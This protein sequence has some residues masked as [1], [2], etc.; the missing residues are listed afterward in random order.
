MLSDKEF[1]HNAQAVEH[2]GV[3]FMHAVNNRTLKFAAG[4]LA[5]DPFVG[6]YGDGRAFGDT[7]NTPGFAEG[8]LVGQFAEGGIVGSSPSA[9]I[10]RNVVS[11]FADGGRVGHFAQGGVADRA[12]F[13]DRLSAMGL[14]TI[15]MPHLAIGGMPD[16]HSPVLDDK[17][18]GKGAPGGDSASTPHHTVDLR[19]DHGTFRMM[20]PEDTVRHLNTAAIDSQTFSTGKKP[21]WYGGGGR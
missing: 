7:G 18:F 17:S 13:A 11:R 8:G 1:V 12:S 3:P 21:G 16:F 5:K 14:G 15:D 20:A 9:A 6:D 4:G 19:T 2:Y 10:L